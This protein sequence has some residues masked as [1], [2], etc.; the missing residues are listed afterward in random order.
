MILASRGLNY[1]QSSTFINNQFKIER[2]T[3]PKTN[4][5]TRDYKKI[6]EPKVFLSYL[7]TL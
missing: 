1:K 6:E 5:P 3:F 4:I 7:S 2:K